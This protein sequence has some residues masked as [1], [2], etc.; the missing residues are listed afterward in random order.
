MPARLPARLKVFKTHIG[1][2]DLIVAAPSMKA[3]AQA[4]HASP[5][6]FAQGFAAPTAE[7]DAVKA[8]LAQ[9]GVV[10]RRP[11][12]GHGAYKADPDLPAVPRLSAARGKA[13]KK[14]ARAHK[15]AEKRA[16]QAAARRARKEAGQELQALAREEA[17]LRQR[18]RA[19]QKKLHPR[20]HAAAP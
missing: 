19:L 11:H 2:H 20:G 10:L 14:E 5:R 15:A 4:W 7:D 1:F 16:R 17:Q 13:L 3:A 18:R 9:P 12:D 8:A 6:L